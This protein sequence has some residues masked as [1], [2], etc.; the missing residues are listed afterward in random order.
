MFNTTDDGKKYVTVSATGYNSPYSF[1]GRY[2]IRNVSS[3]ESAGPEVLIQM[4]LTRGVDPLKGQ[5]SDEQ[6]LTF[7]QLFTMMISRRLHPRDD[8]GF[9]RSHGMLDEQDRFNITTHLVY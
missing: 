1:D 2:F 3:D 5:P 4:V 9:Y 6:D 8:V 7:E